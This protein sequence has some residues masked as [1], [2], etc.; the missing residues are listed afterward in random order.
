MTRALLSRAMTEATAE[1]YVGKTV[2]GQKVD[3]V[4][5]LDERV[6]LVDK[7]DFAILDA[8]FVDT[9]PD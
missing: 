1:T 9:I 2:L 4:L 7:N 8:T 5:V 3:H 6:Y